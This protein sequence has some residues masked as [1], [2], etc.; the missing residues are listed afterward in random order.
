MTTT[1]Q[2]SSASSLTA[3]EP[4][5]AAALPEKGTGPALQPDLE[6][7]SKPAHRIVSHF[8]T[9]LR[10]AG[11]TPEVLAHEYP[12]QGTAESPYLVFFL[13]VDAHNPQTLPSWRKWLYTLTMA[14]ATLAIAFVSSAFSGGI[15]EIIREF[16]ISD[17][18]AILGMSLFVLGFA[19]GPLIWAPMSEYF[20]R[21][22]LFFGTYAIVTAFNAGCAGAK[23]IETLIILRFFAGAFGSS[24]LTNA[25]G[26]IADM[27]SAS[28]R[29]MAT[30]IFAAAPFLGS[31][32]SG[33]MAAFTGVMWIVGTLI[34]PETYAPYLLRKRA[35]EL[36]RRTGKFYVSRLDAHYYTPGK[37]GSPPPAK[38]TVGHQLRTA[39]CRPWI[40]LF[41]EPIVFVISLYMAIIYGTMYMMFDAFPIVFEEVRGWS[42]GIGGLAFLGIAVGMVIAVFYA[43]LD[44]HFRYAKISLAHKGAAPPEAR[45]FSGAIGAVLIPVGLFWFAWTNRP[46]VHWVVP[47]IGSGFFAAGLVLV[48]LSLMN[49]LVDTYVVFAASCLA[50]NAVLRSLFGAAF[51]LFTT[52]MY[53]NL[54]LHWAASIP[55]FLALACLPF[56]F[57]FMRYGEQI[58]MRCKFAAE[59]AAILARMRQGAAPVTPPD[60][61]A[62]IQEV[63]AHELERRLTRASHASRA[64]RASRISRR[65]SQAINSNEKS[66][67]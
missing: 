29:G 60:E 24:P 52:Y 34:V 43:G 27:F 46:P 37:D 4:G 67:A 61:D 65:L 62:A 35:Q 32:R 30:A 6:A 48:F 45:L 47:I 22:M 40:L 54:G 12:G 44:N 58:R 63:N 21:Q 33:L 38:P 19:V 16:H 57:L 14:T 2:P 5:T 7:G 50:A 15:S 18:V 1:V 9:L 10:P 59:A 26:V 25:G 41:T 3:A 11:V 36:S 17:E 49:Y 55:A 8:Q 66:D 56:P 28:E 53:Q 39:L 20:G 64:S 13:D 31:L 23:N 42:A 51:P